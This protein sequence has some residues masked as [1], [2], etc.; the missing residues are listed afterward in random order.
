MA[1]GVVGLLVLFAAC[2]KEIQE[3][4]PKVAVD[5]LVDNGGYEAEDM[6]SSEAMEAETVV[7]PLGDDLYAYATLKPEPADELRAEVGL[8]NGQRVYMEAYAPGGNTAVATAMYTYTGGKLVADADSPLGVEPGTYDFVAY[9]YYGSTSNPA[10]ANIDPLQSD[11]VWGKATSQP[12][13]ATNRTVTIKMLHKFSQVRVE[14]NAGAVATAITTLTGVRI[15]SCK[16]VNLSVWNGALTEV[17]T[18]THDATSFSNSGLTRTS[19]YRRFYPS[20]TKVTIEKIVL[21]MI[22][23]GS[24]TFEGYSARFTKGL[25]GGKIYTLVLD[26]KRVLWSRSNIYWNGSALTFVGQGTD[27]T[28]QGYQG[29]FFK[30]GSLVGISPVGENMV[31]YLSSTPC[32]QPNG[33]GGWTKTYYTNYADIPCVVGNVAMPSYNSVSD[34]TG[35]ICRQIDSQYRM[36]T[37]DEFLPSGGASWGEMPGEYPIF[38][39]SDDNGTYDFIANGKSYFTNTVGDVLFPLSGHRYYTDGSVGAVGARAYYWSSSRSGTNGIRMSTNANIFGITV[40][41]WDVDRNHATPI[42]CIKNS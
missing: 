39:N 14:L 21:T 42:R 26:L 20:P 4:G 32:Y 16:K 35:D 18:V 12:I 17:S 27:L 10:T 29:V 33:S 30:W 1:V 13:T 19:T 7:V 25:T 22:G 37:S 2:E 11:L 3:K 24:K 28:K 41:T 6:R 8:S 34:K 5:F 31:A 23:G 36:P 40:T 38:A 15:E 9:S